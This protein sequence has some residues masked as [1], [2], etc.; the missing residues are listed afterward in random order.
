MGLYNTR[1][2]N[3]HNVLNTRK[4]ENIPPYFTPVTIPIRS[5]SFATKLD[6]VQDIDRWIYLTLNGRY[7]ITKKVL[8]GFD[9]KISLNKTI[10]ITSPIKNQTSTFDMLWSLE[11]VVGFEEP[12]EA[13]YF[14]LTCPLLNE[15]N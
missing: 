10:E 7:C 1:T 3:P 5:K 12:S 13:S 15:I 9:T 11:W 4:C 8:L 6:L 14:V 2:V